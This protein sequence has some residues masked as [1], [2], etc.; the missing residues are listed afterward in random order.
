MRFCL[1]VGA[2]TVVACLVTGCGETDGASPGSSILPSSESSTSQSTEVT[3]STEAITSTT[4][5]SPAT[6]T[7]ATQERGANEAA[8]LLFLDAWRQQDETAMAAV[9]ES[10]AVESALSIGQPVGEG[11]ARCDSQGN[12]QYECFVDTTAGH[13]AYLLVGEP[14]TENGRV[15]WVGSVGQ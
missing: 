14:G 4:D 13:E 6:S 3:T 15:W 11:F 2:L 8:A 7:T 9:A 1:V 12:G 5:S 10:E